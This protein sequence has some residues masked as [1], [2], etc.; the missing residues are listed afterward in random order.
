MYLAQVM[1]LSGP[2]AQRASP[3]CVALSS[4]SPAGPYR[5][6]V[7][8]TASGGAHG[9]HSS[10]RFGRLKLL[11]HWLRTD[12]TGLRDPSWAL[13]QKGQRGVHG[14]VYMVM[15]VLQLNPLGFCK[16]QNFD[17]IFFGVLA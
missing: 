3:H 13:S 7:G 1:A 11:G 12:R 6:A 5:R 14:L 2:V 16:L 15:E 4:P 8:Q 9:W 17:I 10:H